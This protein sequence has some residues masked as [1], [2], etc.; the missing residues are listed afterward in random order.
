MQII[1]LFSAD[2]PNIIHKE[3]IKFQQQLY[4][5]LLHRY[6]RAK[7]GSES[8]A[9]LVF[10]Q[11]VYILRDVRHQR[12]VR[13]LN[14]LDVISTQSYG[15]LLKEILDIPTDSDNSEWILSA[16]ERQI[17]QLRIEE[18]RRFNQLSQLRS[19]AINSDQSSCQSSL[20][21][22]TMTTTNDSF[23]TSIYNTDTDQT[24][25]KNIIQTH[26]TDNTNNTK[27]LNTNSAV[28]GDNISP[29]LYNN[30]DFNDMEMSLFSEILS[31]TEQFR[32]PVSSN[33]S[34]QQQLYMYLLEKYLRKK[35]GSECEAKIM[36]SNIMNMLADIHAL[37]C[38]HNKSYYENPSNAP[39]LLKEI[40]DIPI[41]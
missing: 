34:F 32:R 1:L 16:K 41:D 6:L 29:I 39:L 26:N 7:Y 5:H 33:I 28:I 3:S 30:N 22:N 2:K 20:D 21:S 38:I 19:V 24:V 40:L 37:K 12:E 27:S 14:Q 36:F 8:D 11:M 35:Y 13:R 31:A 17:R 15:P 23:E 25:D 9:R 10:R 18:N 4:V